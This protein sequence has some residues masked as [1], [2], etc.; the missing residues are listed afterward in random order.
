[1]I[2]TFTF[3]RVLVRESP[4]PRDLTA[5]PMAIVGELEV[6]TDIEA[7]IRHNNVGSWSMSAP[8]QHQQAQLLQPS[9]GIV[10][11][12]DGSDEPVFSGPIRKLVRKWSDT[13]DAGAGTIH[14]TGL[15]DNVFLSE[16][17]A[18]PNPAADIHLQGTRPYWPVDL[19]W[20]HAGDVLYNLLRANT[21]GLQSRRFAPLFIKPP[22]SDLLPDESV[23]STRLRFDRID[24]L[25]SLLASVYGLAVRCMWHPD[26]KSAGGINGDPS[27][28]GPGLLVTFVKTRDLTQTARF[29][30]D[31]GNL[32]GYSYTLSA[33]TATRLVIGAQNR[34]WQEA[35]HDPTYDELGNVTGYSVRMAEKE[36]PERWYGY[37][38]NR[39]HDPSWWGDQSK[40][41]S[42]SKGTLRWAQQGLSAAE[43]EWGMTTEAF[44]DRRDIPW[45]WR[46]DPTRQPGWHMDPPTWSAHHRALV[47]E[48]E[49][50]NLDSGMRAAITIQPI[51]T[52][53]LRY[54]LDYSV[55]DRAAVNVD[56]VD[57][58]ELVSEVRLSANTN[59]GPR[60]QLTL[61]SRGTTETPYLY[62]S[63]RDLWM[64][65]H[66]LWGRDAITQPLDTIPPVPM[67]LR[68]AA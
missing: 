25:A 47:D 11:V 43:V 55:G 63:I 18:W 61:G 56:G 57:Q 5:V 30:V 68:K 66:G 15:D 51:E 7:I 17:L 10:I 37:H 52:P 24:E 41:P 65:L 8:A 1:L 45:Q 31:M 4:F 36:G 53:R 26:P 19:K 39:S 59:D 16:R 34:T 58:Q 50:F 38:V 35:E 42:E 60:V 33:P 23:K 67:V 54:H 64:S 12:R 21:Q 22:A 3:F 13:E 20:R 9:R 46:Q 40:T 44:K 14:V 2:V 28:S 6:F 62:K 27:A 29:S 32:R 48:A 49:A